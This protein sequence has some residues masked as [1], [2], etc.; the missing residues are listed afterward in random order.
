M[1]PILNGFQKA[2]FQN[3][4][5]CFFVPAVN[6]ATRLESCPKANRQMFQNETKF[7]GVIHGLYFIC[8]SKRLVHPTN[9]MTFHFC[10]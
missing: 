1:E 4:T 6:P 3:G 2:Q 8:F 5:E 9:K 10:R 7:Y